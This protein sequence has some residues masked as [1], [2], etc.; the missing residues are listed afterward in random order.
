VTQTCPK[1]FRYKVEVPKMEPQL[2]EM[3][4]CVGCGETMCY[5]CWQTHQGPCTNYKL[6]GQPVKDRF[7]KEG[8]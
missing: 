5:S 7:I 2:L 8:L 6:M 4:K 1:C 3:G